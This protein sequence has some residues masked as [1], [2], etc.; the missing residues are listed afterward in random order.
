MGY[1]EIGMFGWM[2]TDGYTVPY[3]SGAA[4]WTN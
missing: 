4:R 3:R 1:A 2:Q